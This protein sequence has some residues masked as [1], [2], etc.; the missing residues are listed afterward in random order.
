LLVALLPPSLYFSAIII[1]VALLIGNL[2]YALY[3]KVGGLSGLSRQA[4]FTAGK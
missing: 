2:T 1:F 4:V 3:K